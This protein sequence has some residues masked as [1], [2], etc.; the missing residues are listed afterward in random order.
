MSDF[1]APWEPVWTP[2]T[3]RSA[4]FIVLTALTVLSLVV[5]VLYFASSAFARSG[6][7]GSCGGA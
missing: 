7:A 1:D 5:V 6:A 2:S 3:G 4:R